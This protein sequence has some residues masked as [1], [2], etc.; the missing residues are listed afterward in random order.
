[1]NDPLK[2]FLDAAGLKENLFPSTSRY[3]G[4]ETK[5]M[6]TVGGEKIV[7]L[8]RRF[9]PQPERFALLQEHT[10]LQGERLD[11]IA[12]KYL[13]DAEQFWRI[14]D[15][16]GALSPEELTQPVGKKLRITLPEGIKG[17]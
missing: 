8:R 5:T 17:G 16:N 13:G 2:P 4:I 7:Y 14:C 15:A 12:A 3:F 6:E 1:M 11:H 10:V 9:C